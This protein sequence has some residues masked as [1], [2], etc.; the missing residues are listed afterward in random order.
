MLQ[1]KNPEH[2]YWLDLF[3]GLAA[4]VV[5]TTHCRTML[6]VEYGLLPAA[7][8]TVQTSIFF[9]LTR[10]AQE[11]VLL[12]F[13]LS[14]FLVGGKVIQR[15]RAG[16]F[17]LRSYTLD[18][19]VRI[20]LPLLSA[21]MLIVISNTITGQQ[22]SVIDYLGNIVSLQ[23]ILVPWVSGPLW[24][25]AYEVWF[26]VLMGAVAWWL[27]TSKNINRYIGIVILFIC[28]LIFSHLKAT[29]LFIWFLGAM[30]FFYVKKNNLLLF[31]G[32]LAL[33]ASM[34][35]LQFF[36][37]ESRTFRLHDVD[38]IKTICELC[39]GISMCV[40]VQQV[41]HRKPKNK[42]GV[43]LNKFGT[44]LA[45]F[46]YTLY[47][48]HLPIVYMLVHFGFPKSQSINAVSIGYYL[49]AI[50]ISLVSAYAI[51]FVFERRTK[52]VKEILKMKMPLGERVREQQYQ[53]RA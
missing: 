21:L 29:Y 6:F 19:T 18:R 52:Y 39:L 47:L 28:F 17:D 14:G 15:L 48:T 13:V 24:S 10:I 53:T 45:D 1:N 30:S 35:T 43:F 27:T 34:L 8:K 12:F 40:I 5:V 25:L 2:Y 20:M 3:R 44:R 36:G 50:A 38:N 22:F 16:T 42:L 33:I 41:I 49:S 32:I 4:L 23:G 7:D 9:F 51:Y 26:Y 37:R 31:G 46:S 11:A